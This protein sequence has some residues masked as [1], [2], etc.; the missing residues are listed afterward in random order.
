MPW[1]PAHKQKPIKTSFP[2]LFISNTADP[3]T[4]L[5]AGV[6]MA[7]KFVDA[8]LIEQKSMGHCSLSAVSR[9][10]TQ[11]IAAYFTQ[12]KV[13]PHPVKSGNG[14]EL[15]DGKWDKCEADEWP[16][17]PFDPTNPPTKRGE[18][19]AAEIEIMNASKRMQEIFSKLKFWTQSI[20]PELNVDLL[21]EIISD[22]KL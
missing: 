17:H 13:P 18:M 19:T 20:G 1:D 15:V 5:H 22:G 11:K 7:Q 3:V 12:G 16:F 9:C 10:T 2:V 14:R 6:K 4:P 21:H 8:G